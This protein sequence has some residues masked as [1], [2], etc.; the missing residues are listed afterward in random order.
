V[1]AQVESPDERIEHLLAEIELASH[2][3]EALRARSLV[4]A[5]LEWHQR[6]LARMLELVAA[7][8]PTGS[9]VVQELV[10]DPLVKSLLE[11]HDL[12]DLPSGSDA[13]LIPPERLVRAPAGRDSSDARPPDACEVCGRSLEEAHEHLYHP[14]DRA[15]RCCCQPCATV[16][17][18]R[19]GSPWKR[20]PP[21]VEVLPELRWSDEDWARLSI[22]IGLAFFQKSSLRAKTVAYY[23]SP[24]GAVESAGLGDSWEDVERAN[25]R[26]GALEPDVEALLVHRVGGAREHYLVSIDRAYELV[27][28]LRR[29]WRGLSGGGA[30]WQ[31][32]ARFFEH[33][34][35]GKSTHA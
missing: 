20:V 32:V 8:G 15:I 25:P 31:G 13:S 5:V 19:A 33:L 14:A 3:E 24:A 27:G 21:R 35:S 2:E 29:D 12:A 26:L 16:L 10:K 34:K 18:A 22:P 4:Q 23:P 1:A 30:A 17:G 11:L 6:G 9:V 7:K 28:Q